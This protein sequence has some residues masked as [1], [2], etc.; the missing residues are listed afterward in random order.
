MGVE[1]RAPELLGDP[2]L[3]VL[4]WLFTSAML[5]FE[6]RVLRWHRGWRGLPE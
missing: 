3:G 1:R 5:R 2:V 4:A 6:K